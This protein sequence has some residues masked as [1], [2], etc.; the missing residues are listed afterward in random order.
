MFLFLNSAKRERY[1]GHTLPIKAECVLW[2]EVSLWPFERMQR[3]FQTTAKIV[4][5]LDRGGKLNASLLTIKLAEHLSMVCTHLNNFQLASTYNLQL[6]KTDIIATC[7]CFVCD[8]DR[9]PSRF[10]QWQPSAG[11]RWRGTP[12]WNMDWSG[13]SQREDHLNEENND[14]NHGPWQA[15]DRRAVT[16]IY[17]S[18]NILQQV[19]LIGRFKGSS[20]FK[21]LSRVPISSEN[22][23]KKAPLLNL[24]YKAVLLSMYKCIGVNFN[25]H[26]RLSKDMTYNRVCTSTWSSI[27]KISFMA[28][29]SSCKAGMSL[30]LY[31]GVL[32]LEN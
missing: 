4:W 9:G 5:P 13:Q 26:N 19:R 10:Q 8:R 21:K 1:K 32:L 27:A 31:C 22:N 24:P 6:N 28:Y 11:D 14:Y 2:R 25:F 20:L 12:N 15:F 16:Q 30:E 18:F 23:K 17:A 7:C 3:N 29:H